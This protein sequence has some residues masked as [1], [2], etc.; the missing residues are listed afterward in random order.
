VAQHD[1]GA[2]SRTRGVLPRRVVL[3]YGSGA[4][5]WVL[6]DR[7]VLTW[8]YFAYV[9]TPTPSGQ[10]LMLPLTFG[11]VF[12]GGRVI[13]ALADPVIARWSDNHTGR[14]G[15]RLP[16][17]TFSALPYVL[18]YVA[19]FLPPVAERSPLNG[20]YLGVG[21]AIYFVLFTAYVGPYLALLADLS[22]TTA[23]RVD[24]STAKAVATLVGAG[25]A[26]IASGLLVDAVGIV[27]M[28]VALGA[29]ALVL[30]LVPLTIPE[31]RYA[32]AVPATMALLPAVRA[33][34][35]NR[36]FVIALL[37]ANALWFGF[38]IVSLNVPLYA[39]SLL[40]LTEGA[41][42]ALMGALFGVCLLVFPLVNRVSKRHG[43]KR[44]M[45]ASLVGFALVFPLIA[46][47]PSPPFGLA[48]LVYGV[49]VMALAGV[50]L[51]GFF[52]VP[53]AIIAAVADLE[54][55]RT[56]QRR[57]GMYFGVNGLVLKLNLG[58]STVVSAALLQWW[59]DPLGL[60]ATGPVA[61]VAVAIGAAIFLR[62]PEAEVEA[63]RATLR[64][65]QAPL[66]TEPGEAGDG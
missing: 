57:E 50:P 8:L 13:D 37:G 52:V 3:A 59:G 51:A 49:T 56:G 41:V 26:L 10:R 31:R 20:L 29:V 9:T 54:Q 47:F 45:I 40:G 12:F 4:A 53:D 30:L 64:R 23:D 15:R 34:F 33:T 27:T 14:R 5:G 32:D 28:V 18:V 58:L 39:T 36:P 55:Q 11:L 6:V 2:G 16:F 61:A 35:A 22:V 25:V 17:L 1:P 62:Y 46:A 21:L 44:V 63:G 48:P 43:L 66:G 7:V 65:S 42:T 24:L 19:L 60:Q 38:N